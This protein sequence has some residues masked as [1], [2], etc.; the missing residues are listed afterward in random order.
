MSLYR[1]FVGHNISQSNQEDELPGVGKKIAKS[2]IDK[3]GKKMV[4]SG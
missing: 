4:R 3:L 2:G 1:S